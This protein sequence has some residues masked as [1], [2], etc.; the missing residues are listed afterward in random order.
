MIYFNYAGCAPAFFYRRNPVVCIYKESSLSQVNPKIAEGRMVI[1]VYF[2]M[3][4]PCHNHFGA[5][6]LLILKK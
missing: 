3:H 6:N 2:L 5:I 1:P 4:Y